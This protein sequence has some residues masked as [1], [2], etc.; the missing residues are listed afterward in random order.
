M[1]Q[2]LRYN[3][4]NMNQ[5]KKIIKSISSKL[6]EKQYLNDTVKE[7][8][9]QA[10]ELEQIFAMHRSDKGLMFRL[11][12][13]CLEINNEIIQFKKQAKYLN[14]HFIKEDL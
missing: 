5:K 4:E 10:T 14:R 8:K 2:A 1:V 7:M 13:E 9:M 11:Y 6:K 12:K 3:A